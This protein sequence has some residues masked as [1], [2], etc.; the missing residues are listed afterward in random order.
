MIFTKWLVNK[1]QYYFSL[2]FS[3]DL[4]INIQKAVPFWFASLIVGLVAVIYTKL[5]SLSEALL[6]VIL[7][8]NSWMIFI[9]APV[10]FLLAW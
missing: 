1:L 10:C 8:W 2:I 4:K 3:N 5:F 7:Q 9:M 6:Q